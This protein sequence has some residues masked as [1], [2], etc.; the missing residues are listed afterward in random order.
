MEFKYL[1][2]CSNIDFVWRQGFQKNL[3]DVNLIRKCV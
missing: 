2:F 1:Q 3:A